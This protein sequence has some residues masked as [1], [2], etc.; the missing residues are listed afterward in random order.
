MSA[1]PF[2]SIIYNTRTE[3]LAQWQLEDQQSRAVS[4]ST[5][6]VRLCSRTFVRR[7]REALSS[8][9]GTQSI[10]QALAQ[11]VELFPRQLVH[12]QP[13]SDLP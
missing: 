10:F 3:A 8:F 7:R 2:A 4:L 11:N 1:I 6:H 12:R 9:L 13:Q 5:K